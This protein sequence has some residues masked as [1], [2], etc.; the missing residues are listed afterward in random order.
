MSPPG[1]S[2]NSV[3]IIT[4]AFNEA[5]HLPRVLEQLRKSRPE[6]RLLVIDDGSTDATA[7][8]ARLR[9]A[10]VIKHPF[11]LGYGASLQTGVKYA[12]RNRYQFAVFLDA[13]GQHDPVSISTL[14]APCLSGS[15]D[16]VIGSRFLESRSYRPTIL[17]RTAMRL[18]AFITRAL[19]GLPLTDPT[20]GYLALNRK[21]MK[22][23]ASP[24][25]PADYPDANNLIWLHRSGIA[26]LEAPALMHASPPRRS[27]HPGSKVFYYFFSIFISI[28]VIFLRKK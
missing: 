11:N 2:D 10:V 27:M 1:K 12:L 4:P 16:L 6:D 8:L 24:Y 7:E 17:R 9:G 18:L 23:I 21:A 22:K 26:I 19:T 25:F 28:L 13:D 14:L 15:A 3:L 20:S 5:P